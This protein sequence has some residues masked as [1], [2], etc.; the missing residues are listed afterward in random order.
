M[1]A[2]PK[3]AAL[4]DFAARTIVIDLHSSTIFLNELEEEAYIAKED[5]LV[6]V[7]KDENGE[8]PE[9]SYEK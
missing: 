4:H 5:G 7:E 2:S 9:L 1:M 8:E 3:K 6:V